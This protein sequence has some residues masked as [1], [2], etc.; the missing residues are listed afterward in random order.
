MG[1]KEKTLRPLEREEILVWRRCLPPLGDRLGPRCV[2][3]ECGGGSKRLVCILLVRG[4]VGVPV[5]IRMRQSAFMG[6]LR[7]VK[8]S[9]PHA[10]LA[11]EKFCQQD[12]PADRQSR[13]S[14]LLHKIVTN[15]LLFCAAHLR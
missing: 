6:I 10:V 7:A 2:V 11:T 13:G 9:L 4:E 8:Q 1:K 15:K 5:S 3:C 12:P 14:R